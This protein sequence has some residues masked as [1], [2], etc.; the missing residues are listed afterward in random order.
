[1]NEGRCVRG[2]SITVANKPL[3]T[4]GLENCCAEN[5]AARDRIGLSCGGKVLT[6]VGPAGRLFEDEEA[7]KVSAA[8]NPFRG[9]FCFT[10]V[11]FRGRVGVSSERTLFPRLSIYRCRSRASNKTRQ[12]N[13]ARGRWLGVQS[14]SEGLIWLSRQQGRAR[15]EAKRG[16][17]KTQQSTGLNR[18]EFCRKS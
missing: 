4:A 5:P 11:I 8:M 7:A 10:V 17:V 13:E 12:T 9:F 14:P 3:R 15:R 16:R 18:E 6:S 1:M 2:I